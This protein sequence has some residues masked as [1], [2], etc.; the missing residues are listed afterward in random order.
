VK[1]CNAA[2]VEKLFLDHPR[3]LGETYWQ[4]QR[5]ALRFGVQMIGGGVA[6]VMHAVLPAVF[7][8]TASGT[9]QR[10][11]DEMRIGGRLRGVRADRPRPSAARPAAVTP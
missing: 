4:H 6:C 10:L 8:H 2:V 11:Y 5:R 3:S 7:V 1:A 9:V